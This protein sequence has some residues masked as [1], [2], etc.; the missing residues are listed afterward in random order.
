MQWRN[1]E[2][3]KGRLAYNAVIKAYSPRICTTARIRPSVRRHNITAFHSS[4]RL[5]IPIALYVVLGVSCYILLYVNT[6]ALASTVRFNKPTLP[7]ICLF[8]TANDLTSHSLAMN[9]SSAPSSGPGIGGQA[10]LKRRT[11]MSLEDFRRH[12]VARHGPIA[13]PWCLANGVSYY[14][15]V[16][17]PQPGKLRRRS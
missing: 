4:E 9:S 13:V 11:G 1:S 3:G 14:A 8:K 10:L 16:C 5:C 17:T 12:Y 15:Q 6:Y 7:D 2:T